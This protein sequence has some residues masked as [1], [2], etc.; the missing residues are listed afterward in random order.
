MAYAETSRSLPESRSQHENV[1]DTV[2]VALSKDDTGIPAKGDFLDDSNV[3]PLDYI[4]QEV[5]LDPT[6]QVGRTFV[7]ARW[8]ELEPPPA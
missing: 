8:S 3:G 6:Q 5:R 7:Y 4:C 1:I 2:G